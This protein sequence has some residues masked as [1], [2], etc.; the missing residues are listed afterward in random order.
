M[1]QDDGIG[2]MKQDGGNG[3]DVVLV[4]L[5][6]NWFTATPP[7]I[8]PF[9]GGTTLS[10]DVSSHGQVD[11]EL[12]LG[13]LAVPYH[14]SKV[15]DAPETRVYALWGNFQQSIYPV[16]SLTVPIDLSGCVDVPVR[17]SALQT[18]V[19]KSFQDQFGAGQ[20][21]SVLGTNVTVTAQGPA[22]LDSASGVLNLHLPFAVSATGVPSA[23]A[24]ID[25]TIQ[26]VAGGGQIQDQV[27]SFNSS[28]DLPW[29]AW[30]L[31]FFGGL[32]IT[33]VMAA[34]QG[35]AREQIGSLAQQQVKSTI[36]A[37]IA[38]KVAGLPPVAGIFA[39]AVD[40]AG[41]TVTVCLR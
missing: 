22:G 35:M 17:L 24:A 38:D 8:K 40:A 1:K 20:T 31:A 19:D 41:L 9:H 12:T 30:V 16:G 15:V 37:V 27:T 32:T 18:A 34:F 26:L 25:A 28:F 14:G 2:G 29:E 3:G 4:D 10:W 5:R 21:Y 11:P 39:V 36:D 33:A 23:S 13:G 7:A 6:L